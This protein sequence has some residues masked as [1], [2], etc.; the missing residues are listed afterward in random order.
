MILFLLA[1]LCCRPALS[2][3]MVDGADYRGAEVSEIPQDCQEICIRYIDIN[4][5]IPF[6]PA[7]VVARLDRPQLK[8]LASIG[9]PYLCVDAQLAY[10]KAI[11]KKP[12]AVIEQALSVK[13][14]TL[15]RKRKSSFR[16][17][18]ARR[19]TEEPVRPS[20]SFSTDVSCFEFPAHNSIHYLTPDFLSGEWID[21]LQ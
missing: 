1:S 11:N 12:P 10:Y 2:L 16:P 20:F 7:H 8:V 3:V 15:K 21:N 5:E 9:I 14:P 17:V 6:L 19:V 13:K 4:N 18:Q